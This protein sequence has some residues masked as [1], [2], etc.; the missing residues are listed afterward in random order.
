MGSRSHRPTS[1]PVTVYL[2]PTDGPPQTLTAELYSRGSLVLK[3]VVLQS[4][5]KETSRGII[6]VTS[7]NLD[8]TLSARARIYNVGGS[9]GEFGQSMPALPVSLLRRQ[10]YLTGLSGIEGNR[11]NVAVVNP[12]DAEANVFISLFE[13]S[14]ELRGGFSVSVAP[15]QVYQLNDIFAAFGTPPFSGAT[16]QVS[17]SSGV[18]T[19][20]TIIRNDNGAPDILLGAA[21]G[22]GEDDSAPPPCSNPAPLYPADHPAPGWIVVFQD[23]VDAAQTTAE[24]AQKYGFTPI[25]VYEAAFKGFTAELSA[26]AIASLRCEPVVKF[27]EQ[28][29]QYILAL[30]P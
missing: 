13:S 8:A 1:V 10:N 27:I 21:P 14:G 6:R 16:V 18:Y 12:H 23:T 7:Q 22:L 3:D 15:W 24:F 20:A 5:G 9:Q 2:I 17:S 11:T 29:Q 30:T 28:N 4:F 25:S 26:T 19:Y